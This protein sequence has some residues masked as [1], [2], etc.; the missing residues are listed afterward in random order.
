MKV[1]AERLNRKREGGRLL[2]NSDVVSYGKWERIQ[3]GQCVQ[4]GLGRWQRQMLGHLVME[5][6]HRKATQVTMVDL[7][8]RHASKDAITGQG[9]N[10]QNQTTLDVVICLLL[11]LFYGKYFQAEAVLSFQI[12]LQLSPCGRVFCYPH[13][14][15]CV[16]TFCLTVK[17]P[18]DF[19]LICKTV[20]SNVVLG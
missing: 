7:A 16:F 2:R 13:V 10:I 4:H 5:G 19:R 1:N 9:C 3:N 20:A 14:S 8:A 15:T 11:H 6:S 12:Y 18:N 17:Q